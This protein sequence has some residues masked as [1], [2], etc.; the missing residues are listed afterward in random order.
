[1]TEEE[2][3]AIISG[4]KDRIWKDARAYGRNPKIYLHWTAGTYYQ[5][6]SDYHFCITGD[7]D[8]TMT[9]DFQSEANATWKRNSGSVAIALCCA[10]NANEYTLGS[11][12]PTEDQIE[13][14]AALIAGA[15]TALEVPIDI[16]HVMTHGEAANNEDG[17]SIHMPYAWWNDVYGDGD[18]RGDLEY[19]G[20]AESPI[21]DPWAKDGSRG[22]DVLRAKALYYQAMEDF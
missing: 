11:Y 5:T 21:Y 20:T 2:A 13:S 16:Y 14:M 6:F 17:L 1:M 15:C 9:H 12:P 18:T 8:I 10:L 3:K 4:H 19:L 22:G 7:G